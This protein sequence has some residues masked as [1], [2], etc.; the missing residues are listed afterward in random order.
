MSKLI[1]PPRP[2]GA[3]IGAACFDFK[4]VLIDHRS[5]GQPIAGMPPLLK[6]LKSH[7]FLLA[8]ISRNPVAVVS[9][10]LG[11]LATLFGGHIYSSGGR[12]KLSCLITFARTVDIRDLAHIAFV[13][14]KSDNL[15]PIAKATPVRVIGFKGSGKY[16]Q[17]RRVC[18][19]NHIPFVEHVKDLQ[20]LLLPRGILRAPPVD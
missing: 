16:P 8:V 9:E 18:R 11:A 1:S 13:D 12:D 5:G 3:P 20:N 6:A 10:R 19:A 4:G 7:G 2:E 14:D 15:L 17:A